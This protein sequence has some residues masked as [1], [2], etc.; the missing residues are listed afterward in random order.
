MDFLFTNCSSPGGVKVIEIKKTTAELEW[1]D[2]NNNGRPILFYNI[3][4]RTNWNRTW[5]NVTEEVISQQ[6][7]RNTKR[8]R[9]TVTNLTPW[10]GYEFSVVAVNDLGLSKPSAPSPVY[11][12]LKD[13]PYIYPR[14]IGGGGKSQYPILR[15]LLI[16]R[17]IFVKVARLEI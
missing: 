13:K 7:D 3:L 6:S 14:N 15:A 16:N 4:G 8:R 9:A 10:S 2:G 17:M 12:T 1:I 11:N 5:D